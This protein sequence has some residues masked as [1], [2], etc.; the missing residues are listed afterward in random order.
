[1]EAISGHRLQRHANN[2]HGSVDREPPAATNS[3]AAA[4]TGKEIDFTS[5]ITNKNLRNSLFYVFNMVIPRY[6]LE[7][8]IYFFAEREN[9]GKKWSK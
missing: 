6:L 5:T 8:P 7:C 4:G 1:M 9:L 3:I 2:R